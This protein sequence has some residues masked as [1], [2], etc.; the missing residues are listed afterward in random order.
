MHRAAALFLLLVFGLPVPAQ[1]P[2]GTTWLCNLSADVVRLICVADQ[3]PRD[4]AAAGLTPVVTMAQVRGTRFPLDPARTWIVDLWS[5]PTEM[6]SVELLARSTICHR[7]PG[8]S[9]T[10]A[11]V[12]GLP[13]RRTASIR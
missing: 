12:A 3:D 11:P 5:V 2:S 8:C 7:S 9:V 1:A 4:E 13:Q 10:V 6:E